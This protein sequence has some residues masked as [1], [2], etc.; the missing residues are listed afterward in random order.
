MRNPKY[1]LGSSSTDEVKKKTQKLWSA[2]FE[3]RNP[4]YHLGYSST[5]EVKKKKKPE[6]V[7]CWSTL[8]PAFFHSIYSAKNNVKNINLDF[9]YEVDEKEKNITGLSFGQIPLRFVLYRHYMK[10]PLRQ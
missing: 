7:D 4:K 1:H 2:F 8:K 3:L 10:S 9:S 6:I 5:D